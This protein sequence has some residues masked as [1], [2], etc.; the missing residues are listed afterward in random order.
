MVEWVGLD[1]GL[2]E[3]DRALVSAA[4]AR[5]EAADQGPAEAVR[6]VAPAAVEQVRVGVCGSLAVELATDPGAG[7]RE[8]RVRGEQPGQGAA[9]AVEKVREQGVE[10]AV[11]VARV[12][13]RAAVPEVEVVRPAR[14]MEELEGVGGQA[15]LLQESG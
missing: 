1:T 4:V 3:R 13:V 12:P 9:Q 2:E 10:A 7:A 11:A 5:A 14:A 6:G 15:R 8:R